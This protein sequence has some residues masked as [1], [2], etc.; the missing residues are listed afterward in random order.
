M[1]KIIIIT[2]MIKIHTGSV[3]TRP[4]AVATCIKCWKKN[5][6]GVEQNKYM[7]IMQRHNKG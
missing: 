7:K 2:I 5:E 6:Q 3:K 1:M 4:S